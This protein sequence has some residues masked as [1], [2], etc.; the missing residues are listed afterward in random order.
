[1]Y[2]KSVDTF[3]PPYKIFAISKIFEYFVERELK[4]FA[5]SIKINSPVVFL[6]SA[7]S[8]KSYISL[9]ESLIS[10][11]FMKPVWQSQIITF[12]VLSSLFARAPDAS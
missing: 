6:I 10:L 5:K 11:P 12:R 8:I 9:V 2:N 7:S 3:Y 4:A 1:M